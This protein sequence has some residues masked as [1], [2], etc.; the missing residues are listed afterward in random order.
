MV[1]PLKRERVFRSVETVYNPILASLINVLVSPAGSQGS[2]GGTVALI[3]NQ[4]GFYQQG[5]EHLSCIY[6]VML[7][8]VLHL[9]PIFAPTE[10]LS[11]EE[12]LKRYEQSLTG[13]E[14]CELRV[15]T[16]KSF[17]SENLVGDGNATFTC[18]RDGERWYFR[19][20]GG[21][22]YVRNG[23]AHENHTFNETLF[24]D[25][26][27]TYVKR[28]HPGE[29]IASIVALREIPADGSSNHNPGG[30]GEFMILFGY[31]EASAWIG[32]PTCFEKHDLL[33]R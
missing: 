17:R 13:L 6:G 16:R 10:G 24:I 4:R 21:G 12:L 29:A 14:R 8:L 23:K 2:A 25:G 19:E 15:E 22:K 27:F 5:D 33:P 30:A 1:A 9:T 7:A 26:K 20:I 18:R 31:L 3:G 28:E 32:Y 11:S